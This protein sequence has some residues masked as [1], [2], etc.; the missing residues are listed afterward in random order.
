MNDEEAGTKRIENIL[1]IIERIHLMKE[2][3]DVGVFLRSVR[4]DGRFVRTST[5]DER[6]DTYE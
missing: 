6:N 2:L 3:P 1:N 4:F 5:G